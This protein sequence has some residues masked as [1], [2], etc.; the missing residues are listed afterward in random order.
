MPARHASWIFALVAS[1]LPGGGALASDQT[2][3][4]RPP[5]A[6][7][8]RADVLAGQASPPQR[9][10][11]MKAS[12]D[13]AGG[14]AVEATFEEVLGGYAYPLLAVDLDG[15]G[16][17]ET[18]LQQY[19]DRP[20]VVAV[21]DGVLLWR[22]RLP[23]NAS[24]VGML[25]ADFAPGDGH[26]VLLAVYRWRQNRMILSTASFQGQLWRKNMD[27]EW[28]ELNGAVQAD[29]DAQSEIAI[30]V[31]GDSTTILT[32]DGEDGEDLAEL[33]ST[34]EQRTGRRFSTEAFI[35]DG[36][37]GQADEAVFVTDLQVGF[38][39]ERLRLTDGAQT[40]YKI[41][42]ITELPYLT[43]GPDYTGD[44]RRDGF[45]AYLGGPVSSS[46]G[47]FDPAAL[48]VAWTQ[49]PNADNGYFSYYPTIHPGDANGD[50]AQD[51]CLQSRDDEYEDDEGPPIQSTASFRCLSGKTGVQL[52]TASL[53]VKSDPHG[54]AYA[55]GWAGSDLDG[56]GV[57]DPILEAW[58]VSCGP[59][60]DSHPCEFSYE[61]TAYSGRNGS[62]L[63]SFDD[64]DAWSSP[65]RLTSSNLDGSPGD[66]AIEDAYESPGPGL[67]FSIL[68]G[69]TFESAWVGTVD[70]PTQD[71]YT[72]WAIDPDLDGDG[73]HEALVTAE[74]YV[75]LG[76]P[77][78]EVWEGEQYCWYEDYDE[79]VH[80]AA[81]EPGGK[82]LW[83]ME[84]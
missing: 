27:I 24:V 41:V 23:K 5:V 2:A 18:L 12:I 64:P 68:N 62:V 36:L 33:R 26:E 84:L 21:D 8:T 7:S 82:R 29:S 58:S 19:A 28:F 11:L 17:E 14:Q 6:P 1:L 71:A 60:D 46:I 55:D 79:H 43:Q 59:E 51:L 44:G 4:P 38:H 32:F 9:F 80:V 57:T 31:Y 74:S 78:C 54:Y 65:W 30:T 70:T 39:A 69:L 81:F 83:Q 50:G 52:W 34:I 47:V 15:D 42:P 35:T 20:Y 73:T 13:A 37:E 53:T 49:Q 75:G 40:A 67:H 3:G 61:A 77:T 48:D 76:D 63:W 25:P 66:D 56:D 10:E 45:I 16:D 22:Q 72:S